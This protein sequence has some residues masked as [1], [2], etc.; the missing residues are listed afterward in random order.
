MLNTCWYNRIVLHDIRRAAYEPD[1]RIPKVFKIIFGVKVRLTSVSLL[2]GLMIGLLLCP[3]FLSLAQQKNP[4]VLRAIAEGEREA[5]VQ[6]SGFKWCALG[7]IG[8]P[9]T[10]AVA[11]SQKPPPPVDLLLGKAP[12]YVEALSE[13]YKV[14]ARNLRLR[15]ATVGCFTGITLGFLGYTVYD[16]NAYG[17]WWWETW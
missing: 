12:G 13:A 1:L 9:I 11:A 5:A 7:C 16:Y 15:Y 17:N 6:T 3:P 10:V 2:A 4:A 8:G 14:K